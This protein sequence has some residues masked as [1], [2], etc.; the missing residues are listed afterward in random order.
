MKPSGIPWL[1]DVPE[2]WE[3]VP[4]YKTVC[5]VKSPNEGM[6]EKNLLSLSYGR[7]I[8]KDMETAFGLVPESYAS[9]NRIEPNDIVLRLT[10][11]Q[12]DQKSLR[13]GFSQ[14]RGI[15][16]SAYLTLR[17][18]GNCFAEYIAYAIKLFDFKKGFYGIGSGVRQS[19]KFSEVKRFQVP[20]PP[21]PEQRAIAERIDC[22]VARVDVLREKIKREI[23]RLGD[24][25]KSLIAETVTRGLR[26][27]KMK[28][29]GIPWLGDV[30]TEWEIIR[31]KTFMKLTNEKVGDRKNDFVLLSLSKQGVI[32]R[33]L[34]ESKGKF[35]K[36]FDTYLV[37]R[38]GNLVFCLFDVAETPR[39]V[40]L[41]KNEGMLTGAYTNF[42]IDTSLVLPEFAYYYYIAVD[43]FKRL[44]PY[45]TGLRKIV[46]TETFL[47]LKFPKPT[48][49]EQREIAEYLDRAVSRIDAVV[50]R[51]R[52]QLEKLE[53]F[54]RSLIQ[55]YVTGKREVCQ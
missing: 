23:E 20:N 19:L 12:N 42:E 4:L 49:P 13:V 51:R 24:Y 55:E 9:Y 43:D 39:T 45:Y 2:E 54:K 44:E 21:L 36:D 8:R 34:S 7:I 50:A 16:T 53:A 10:D 46:K 5:Q 14:E 38:P 18:E 25:K 11:L 40:G 33:D 3:I 37:V 26:K 32:I 31:N 41:V 29:S 17:P 28:P 48:L 27:R 15:V 35:P 1:G 52:A 22:E 30:P 6:V 47:S